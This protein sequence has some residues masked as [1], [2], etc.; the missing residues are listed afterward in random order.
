MLIE[1]SVNTESAETLEELAQ[2]RIRCLGLMGGIELT[3]I[4]LV[5]DVSAVLQ[6]SLH[7]SGV[8]VLTG[9][10]ERRAAILQITNQSIYSQS[11][12][13]SVSFTAK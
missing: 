12:H 10:G 4:E 11:Q 2:T 9:R 13:T 6:K 1:Q 8:T 7:H 3:N 5:V